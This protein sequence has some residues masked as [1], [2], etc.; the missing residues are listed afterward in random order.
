M[1]SS[2]KMEQDDRCEE[3]PRRKPPPPAAAA[4]PA[5]RDNPSEYE[6]RTSSRAQASAGKANKGRAPRKGSSVARS[7]A[8]PVSSSASAS[9]SES[10]P[11]NVA[12][13][14]AAHAPA[15]RNAS[16]TS[17][18]TPAS[19]KKRPGRKRMRTDEEG[20]EQK[21]PHQKRWDEMVSK[22]Y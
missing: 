15:D 9:G 12:V 7:A 4:A 3:R 6:A 10:R 14:A 13:A 8:A 21:M 11:R 18:S 1:D 20:V 19:S 16:I 22:D 5:R 2:R 17:S